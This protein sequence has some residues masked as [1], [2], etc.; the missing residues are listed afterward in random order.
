MKVVQAGGDLYEAL[1]RTKAAE[2][3]QR[4]ALVTKFKGDKI[5]AEQYAKAK[6]AQRR[7]LRG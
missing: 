2:A 4:E 1:E 7:K 3:Y 5:A 6:E